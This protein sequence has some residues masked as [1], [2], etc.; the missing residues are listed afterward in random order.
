MSRSYIDVYQKKKILILYL[1]KYIY[2]KLKKLFKK[3]VIFSFLHNFFFPKKQ[4]TN[5]SL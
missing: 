4:F 5:L 1:K 2:K 3:L